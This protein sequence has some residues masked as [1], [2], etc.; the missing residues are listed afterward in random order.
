[1]QV[2]NPLSMTEDKKWVIWV[3]RHH[4]DEYFGFLD[5]AVTVTNASW[6]LWALGTQHEWFEFLNTTVTVRVRNGYFALLDTTATVTNDL[7]ILWALYAR[8]RVRNEFFGDQV[9]CDSDDNAKS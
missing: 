9:K 2:K 5:T 4:H 8:Q 1:M 7:E 6:I 3:P